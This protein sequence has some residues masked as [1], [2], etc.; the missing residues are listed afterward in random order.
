MCFWFS[1][2]VFKYISSTSNQEKSHFNIIVQFLRLSLCLLF[3]SSTFKIHI[4]ILGPSKY[5]HALPIRD[6][7]HEYPFSDLLRILLK[8]NIN[9][10]IGIFPTKVFLIWPQSV[11]KVVIFLRESR[12][13]LRKEEKVCKSVHLKA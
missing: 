5:I 6:V 13:E 2:V 12:I 1:L 8:Q 7:T 11:R 10:A 9:D 3:L 4:Q